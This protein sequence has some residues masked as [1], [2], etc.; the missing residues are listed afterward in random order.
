[1]K[2]LYS[3]REV[4]ETLGIKI[5]TLRDWICKGKLEAVKLPDRHWY[6]TEK[7]Y[8]VLKERNGDAD[9]D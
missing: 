6:I 9:K 8:I 2:K 3:L 1:M 7:Q 4:W 5:R